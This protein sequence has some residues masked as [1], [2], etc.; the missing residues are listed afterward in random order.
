MMRV[1]LGPVAVVLALITGALSLVFGDFDR[2]ESELRN[3]YTQVGA[4]D[5][6]AAQKSIDEAIR[7]WPSNARFYGW[8]G[9]CASQVLPSQCPLDDKPLDEK[10]LEK[11]RQAAADYRHAME[12]NSR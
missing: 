12:L 1:T 4:A 9:Y 2:A 8:R 5:F 6:V 10:S 11:V 3:F 7:L